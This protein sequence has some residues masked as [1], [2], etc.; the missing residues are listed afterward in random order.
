M[1]ILAPAMV[2]GLAMSFASRVFT[3][4][5]GFLTRA[6]ASVTAAMGKQA[7]A[8]SLGM[9]AAYLTGGATSGAGAAGAGAAAAGGGLLRM[10]GIIG[11]V[12]TALV[13]FEGG[14]ENSTRQLNQGLGSSA[15]S[16]GGIF[17][18]LGVV[19]ARVTGQEEK[20]GQDLSGNFDLIGAAMLPVTATFDLLEMSF[21]LLI[22]GFDNAALAVTK[23]GHWLITSTPLK[24]TSSKEDQ[25][26]FAKAVK[27][28]EA[29]LAGS[30]AARNEARRQDDINYTSIRY[31]GREGYGQK[32][33]QDIQS[34]QAKLS[35]LTKGSAEYTKINDDLF[36]L[37]KLLVAIAGP[38]PT[39]PKPGTPG[40][41]PAPKPGVPGAV[42]APIAV[43]P[44]SPAAAAITN[45]ATY[46]A[47]L[48]TKAA[49][50]I[51]EITAVKTA[52]NA[53]TTK[54]TAPSSLQATV[55]SIYR[56]LASG[57]L[58]VQARVSGLP[59]TNPGKKPAVAHAFGTSNPAFFSTTSAAEKWERSMV[60]G[61][62]RVA[63]MT[64]NSREG[65]GGGSPVT[66]NITIHQQPG[67]DAEELASMVAMKIGEAVAQARS[68]SVFV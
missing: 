45:T 8:S 46:T 42:A 64:G 59:T 19:I 68:A 41:T 16:L 62:V 56:I 57:M 65:F 35:T 44:N 49:A 43:P 32:V 67:Q 26:F 2:Q 37:K 50:Q 39:A 1:A 24:Y 63:S 6:G 10:A 17:N 20:A 27:D 40:A 21:R 31:N 11:G 58:Q 4:V 36:A 51:K 7:V 3:G 55:A 61:S 66:N 60:T 48:N 13:L 14:L 30:T 15:N 5:Q 22:E 18:S 47:Q 9:N 53:L 25:D 12:V 29:R 38:S 34:K 28:L 33:A 52:V 23:F 54:M